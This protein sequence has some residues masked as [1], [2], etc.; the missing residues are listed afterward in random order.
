M[1]GIGAADQQCN[2]KRQ[3]GHGG[4]GRDMLLMGLVAEGRNVNSIIWGNT[5][6]IGQQIAL[7]DGSTVT[8]EY[9][10]VEGGWLGRANINVDPSFA[11]PGHRDDSGTPL[12]PTDDT[13]VQG[14]YHLKSQVGR[15]D[16]IS[17]AWVVGRVTSLCIDAGNPCTWLGDEP[18]PDG[19]RI[20]QGAYGGTA[21]ASKSKPACF[22]KLIG[23]ADACGHVITQ[24]DYNLWLSLGAPNC[25]CHW[26]HC[27]GDSNA[28]C[29][30]NAVDV[31]ALRSAWPGLGGSYD[32][33]VDTNYD[34]VINA[35]DVLALR[36]A[37]PGLGGP[38][39]S[40]MPCCE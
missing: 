18:N 34:G 14:D 7:L 28:D 29:E 25:W 8:V 3:C 21:E 6:G 20:N 32:P 4:G 5:A 15:W 27:R 36:A 30:I 10:D 26:C 1:Q 11:A 31:L 12:D 9:S 39:C 35:V 23:T 13:Y 24:A 22:E 37:W 2:N 19:G 17:G 16:P 38:G 33:C 40:G